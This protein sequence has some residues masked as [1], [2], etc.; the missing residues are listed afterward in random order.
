MRYEFVST[1]TMKAY[2]VWRVLD[3][4][5]KVVKIH[6]PSGKL[7]TFEVGFTNF[8]IVSNRCW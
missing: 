4:N 2:T 8:G 6:K 7:V 1:A 3:K 5:G